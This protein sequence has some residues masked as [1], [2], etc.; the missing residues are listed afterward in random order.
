M[1][2]V[3]LD[4]ETTGLSPKGGHRLIEI[5]CVE[6]INRRLTGQH[7]HQYINPERD[8][9]EGAS[10]VHGMYRRDLVDKPVFAEVADEFMAF[11]DGAELIIHNAPFDVGFIEHE[12]KKLK[13]GWKPVKEYCTVFDS[14]VFARKRHPGQKNNLDALCRRYGVNNSARTLHGAL[15]DAEILADLYLVMT[16]GQISLSLDNQGGSDQ[17]TNA[18]GETIQLLNPDRAR[19]ATLQP[20]E[21]ELQLHTEKLLAIDKASNGQCLWLQKESNHAEKAPLS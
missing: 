2:Q 9:D 7:Y 21:A 18:T 11:I 8:I 17:D 16:G 13:K 4:T 19:L 12:L 14:L 15:L 10:N 1:R 6:V 3:V 20:N 5:G